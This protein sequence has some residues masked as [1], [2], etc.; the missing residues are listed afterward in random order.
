M[1]HLLRVHHGTNLSW[2]VRIWSAFLLS[3]LMHAVASWTL[4]PVLP[5]DGFYERFMA[6]F[7]FFIL[8][9]VGLTIEALFSWTPLT[10]LFLGQFGLEDEMIMGR[11]WTFGWLLFSGQWA[12]ECWLKTEQGMLSMP[13]SVAKPILQI[14]LGMNSH[15]VEAKGNF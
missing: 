4:P 6:I 2:F 13:Y 3:G 8:Q 11:M 1:M 5:F 9:P 14:L 15:S 12:L 7:V 10:D